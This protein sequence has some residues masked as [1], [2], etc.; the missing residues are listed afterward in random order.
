LYPAG[1]P[2]W[3]QLI[4]DDD[5]WAAQVEAWSSFFHLDF[6]CVSH[7]V[8]GERH[9]AGLDGLRAFMLDWT[10]PWVTYRVD[11]GEAIDLGERV[12]LLNTDCGRREG[13]A[14]DVR[15][16]LATLWTMRDGKVSRLDL[17]ETRADGLKAAGLPE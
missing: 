9:Y 4:H 16:R 12:L 5:M 1:D 3:V 13:S 2:D 6:E 7:V 17:Y 15:G 8:G 14:Q 11:P 10:V